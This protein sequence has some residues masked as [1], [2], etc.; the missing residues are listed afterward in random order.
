[1]AVGVILAREGTT[2]QPTAYRE[3][4]NLGPQSISTEP[5]VAQKR[6]SK[7]YFLKKLANIEAFFSR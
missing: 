2:M 7:K 5:T 3:R 4:S 1:M 6:T